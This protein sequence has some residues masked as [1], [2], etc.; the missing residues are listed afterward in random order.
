MLSFAGVV[1]ASLLSFAI[2]RVA[3]RRRPLCDWRIWNFTGHK[4]NASFPSNHTMNGAIVVMELLRMHMP[5]ARL[6][7][8]FAGL[9][10]FSR[11]FAGVHYP[12][13]LLGGV[14]IARARASA[15]HA[16]PFAA[17][18]AMLANFSSAVSD[19]VFS[20]K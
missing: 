17:A 7:A 19:W 6:M 2:G 15:I 13:D 18:L 14:A 1:V 10:A 3:E 16:A 8:A 4:A 9:L 20:R 5:R 12:T 11:I